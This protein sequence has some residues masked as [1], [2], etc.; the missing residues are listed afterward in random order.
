MLTVV[1]R[2]WF[3]VATITIV[4]SIMVLIAI[5]PTPLYWGSQ[6]MGGSWDSGQNLWNLWWIE[7]S[8]QRGDVLPYYTQM[9]YAPN[10]VSL[11]YH[12]LALF[13]GFQS[14]LLRYLTGI[15][16]PAAYNSIATAAFLGSA[17][18]AYWLVR[19]L[20]QSMLAGFVAGIIF[21]FSPAHVSRLH[22]GHLEIFTSAQFIP[23]VTWSALKGA[24]TSKWRFVI[25]T[26][27]LIAI[28]GWQSLQLA[29]GS[30]FLAGIVWFLFGYSS[31]NVRSLLSRY[32][33]MTG[34][35]IIFLWPVAY[36]ILRDF[37]SFQGQF[38]QRLAAVLNSPDLF[39]F[40]IPYRSLSTFWKILLGSITDQ[41]FTNFF[42]GNKIAFVGFIVILLSVYSLF[43]VPFKTTWRWWVI[44]AIFFLV[45]LGP[46]LKIQEQSFRFPLPYTLLVEL[47]VIGLG[48]DPTRYAI[49][50]TL[51]LGII[52]GYA[53]EVMSRKSLG[54]RMGAALI[55]VLI[56]VESLAIPIRLDE[57]LEKVSPFF[58]EIALETPSVSAR[59][60]LDVP[61]DLFGAFGPACDYMVDQV[62]HQHPIVSGYIS[63]TPESARR[64][65]DSYPFVYQLRARLEVYGDTAP[66]DFTSGLIEGAMEELRDLKI[67]Y[68]VL[69]KKELATDDTRLTNSVLTHVLSTPIY[70][71]DQIIAWYVPG[72]DVEGY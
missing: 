36:P 37:A 25:G 64:M 12:P 7:Q 1:S 60:I 20:T 3:E 38:D 2:R 62:V 28:I 61:Y 26:A 15:S 32:F 29:L 45:S 65:L 11:A 14:V 18:T 30:V 31:N 46:E 53:I 13:N 27:G 6:M 49:F 58:H 42:Q 55:G 71:D 5:Y 4:Y 66:L 33:A 9:L 40:F 68:V 19:K 70:E 41:S 22:F 51:A 72:E 16:L 69:H 8:V 24:Q 54:H 34:V 63:R 23:L 48:R 10:G 21:A 50:L 44:A 17:I 67:E 39:D 57:R 35:T 52:I 43:V 59:N 56:F 47:P